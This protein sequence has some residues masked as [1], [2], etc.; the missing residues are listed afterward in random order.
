MSYWLDGEG[1]DDCISCFIRKVFSPFA[2]ERRCLAGTGIA[3]AAI[4]WLK[5]WQH[6]KY[7]GGGG[8]L[9]FRLSYCSY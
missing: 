7:G 5:V 1:Y 2:E 3:G 9:Y 8:N 4:A 6:P